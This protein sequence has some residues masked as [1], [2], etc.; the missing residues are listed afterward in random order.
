MANCKIVVLVLAGN[1]KVSNSNL[2]TQRKTWFLKENNNIVIYTYRGGESFSNINKNLIFEVSDDYKDISEKTYLAFKYIEE[3][4]EFDYLFRTNTSSYVDLNALYEFC[5]KN[6]VSK[7][8][9]GRKLTDKFDD[10]TISWVSG[11]EILLSKN[12]VSTLVKHPHNWSF[13]LPDDVAIG[14]VLSSEGYEIKDSKS[15]LFSPKFF[16][17]K[18]FTHEYHFRCRVDSPYYYPRTL[19]RLL[20]SYVHYGVNKKYIKYSVRIL[21]KFIFTV[22]KLFSFKKHKE[23]LNHYFWIFLKKI[24]RKINFYS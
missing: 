17:L 14:D 4:I 6:T 19:D 8:Y 18:N 22:S 1:T 24:L 5:S 12:A 15:I 7:L 11:A 23:Y 3:N 10:K 9:R 13:D 20:I 2:K 21:M 16:N